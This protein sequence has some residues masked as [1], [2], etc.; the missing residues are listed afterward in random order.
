ME[1]EF[2]DKVEDNAAIRMWS[3]KIQLEKGDNLAMGYTS[4]LSGFTRISV[5]QNELQELRDIWASWDD[6][7]KQL[8]YQSYGDLPYLLDIKVDKCLF[9]AM[10][11]FWNPAYSCFTFGKVDLVPT[12]EEYTALL[13]CPKVQVDKVYSKAAG[14]PAFVKKLMNI[15]GMSEQW[16]TARIQQ[17]GD[18]RC[19]PWVSLKDL[20]IAHPDTNRK[21][22]VFALSV[23]GLVM[24]P[25]ALRYIDEG[26]ADFFDRLDKGVTPVPS[27]LAETFRSLS[28]YRRT[29]EGRFIGCAQLLLAWFHSHFWKVDKVSYRV[30][31]ESYSPLKEIA[32]MSRRDDILEENW[33]ALLRNLQEEDVEWRA[34]WFVPDEILYRCGS[35]DWVPLLG[36]W[37]A[38]GY[39]PL[40][41]LRQYRSRQ[42]I[43][44][45]HGLAQ[46]EFAYK[47]KNYRKRV[48]EISDAWKRTHRMKRLAVGSMTTPEYKGWLSNRVND[49]VP[50][51]SLEDVRT[52]EEYLQVIPS[53]LEIVKR[54]FEER[55]A[56][57]GKKIEQLEEEKMHL[58]LDVDVQKL[59]AEKLRKGK[60][61]VEEDLDSL[62]TDYKKLR[63]SIRTAELGKT[64]EQWRQEIQEEKARAD[65]WEKRFH[66]AQTRESTL[67]K[68]LVEGQCE[69]EM[70]A[71]RVAEL[72]R[73]LRQHRGRNSDI[74]LRASLS[75]I[76]DLKRKVEELETVLQNC[77][78]RIELIESNN[79]QWKEQLRRSQD[80]VRDIDHIMG[81]AVAQIREVADYLQTLAV[82]ADVLSVK[83]ELESDR[84]RELACLLKKVK[85][86]SI[87]AKSYM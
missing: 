73:A 79:E 71:A 38:T 82:Q 65:Q 14:A 44:M 86:L 33:I 4:G 66:D 30:F 28:A 78:L 13:H 1:S 45:T 29:G 48:Q 35:F 19:I 23:Y 26:V 53:E 27:I 49:S 39:A 17:K 25:K 62:K 10:A 40:L 32:A 68:C 22:D 3:E 84:G 2:L 31:S 63:M 46:S 80:Q 11:Q 37:G 50:E 70:L 83:Y 12:V 42:F 8:F 16:V 61:K 67:K 7:T 72:E 43:P 41:V 51:P 21:V 76:E 69:K 75:R 15:T 6:E 74:E 60:R 20:I 34:P 58:R 52:M 85:A 55:N 57:L 9:R 56:E 64:S 24:F 54:D 59:E 36:I 77:E 5:T 47:E 87:R 81:E 18:S